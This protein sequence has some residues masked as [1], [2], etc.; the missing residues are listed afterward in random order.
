MKRRVGL[1][2]QPVPHLM[3]DEEGFCDL[4]TQPLIFP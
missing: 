1:I 3:L 2:N 4:F